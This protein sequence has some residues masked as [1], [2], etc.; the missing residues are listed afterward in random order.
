MKKDVYLMLDLSCSHCKGRHFVPSKT[1]SI[2]Y[3]GG[4]SDFRSGGQKHGTIFCNKPLQKLTQGP[5]L[6]KAELQCLL[7]QLGSSFPCLCKQTKTFRLTPRVHIQHWWNSWEAEENIWQCLKQTRGHG[8][9]QQPDIVYYF[10][11]NVL[12]KGEVL[13]RQVCNH[14]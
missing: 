14:T 2:S 11:N 10:H 4:K 5:L 6:K 12:L 1:C 7:P 13:C 8:L 9:F 3:Y